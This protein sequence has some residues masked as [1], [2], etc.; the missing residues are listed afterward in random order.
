MCPSIYEKLGGALKKMCFKWKNPT[1]P[2]MYARP[3][4]SGPAR[5]KGK[6][7]VDPG[8]LKCSVSIFN[9]CKINNEALFM[10][11]CFLCQLL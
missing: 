4:V 11:L 2:E 5:K 3:G 6:K 1:Y 10:P 9:V 7:E 8:R